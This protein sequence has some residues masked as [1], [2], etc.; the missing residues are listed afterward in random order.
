M[1]IIRERKTFWVSLERLSGSF[2]YSLVFHVLKA[3]LNLQ[4][5]IEMRR[6]KQN[7]RNRQK[8]C[9]AERQK[10]VFFSSRGKIRFAFRMCLV[11]GG[12]LS[13][14]SVYNLQCCRSGV[15]TLKRGF[16]TQVFALLTLR[17][18]WYNSI[19]VIEHQLN[20]LGQNLFIF[21]Q[22]SLSFFLFA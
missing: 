16:H 2:Y 4:N 7:I 13:R 12:F 5:Q 8:T 3:H 6:E 17:L 22:R 15:S 14:V 18:R 21:H 20:S 11:V 19:S 9:R 10:K 1:E